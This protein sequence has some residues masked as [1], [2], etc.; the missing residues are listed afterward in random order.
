VAR[1]KD[2]PLTGDKSATP[3]QT[4]TPL[5]LSEFPD[6][7]FEPVESQ[8]RAFEWVLFV[9]LVLGAA[10]AW[11][12]ASRRIE[13][14]WI[15]GDE[16]TYSEYAKSFAD[17][18][19]FTFRDGHGAYVSIYPALIAAAWLADS[20]ETAYSAAKAINVLLMTL[21]AIPLFLWARRLV[22]PAYALIAVLLTLVMPSFV[23][24]GVLMTESAFLPAFVLATFAVALTLERPTLFRQLLA[25][26]AIALAVLIRL[27]GFVFL[28]IVPTAIVLMALFDLRAER[29]SIRPRSLGHNLSPYAAVA[30]LGVVALLA[31]LVAA[32]ATGREVT[33]V[34]SAYEDVPEADYTVEEVLRWTVTHLGELSLAVGLIPV[35][36]LIV[37]L[38][39]AWQRGAPFTPSQRAFLAVTAAAIPWVVLQAAAF[40]SE[41]SLR[42]QERNMLYLSPL[43]FLALVLWL[44]QGLPRPSG[45]T[46]IAVLLPT[47]LLVAVPL[48]TLFNPSLF[49]DSFALIPFVRLSDLL[50]GGIHAA[51]IVLVVGAIGAGLLFAAFPRRLM[52]PAIPAALTVFLALSAYSVSGAAKTQS[53][54]KRVAYLLGPDPNWID[55]RLGSDGNAAFLYTPELNADPDVVLQSEFWNRSVRD[56]YNV[57]APAYIFP[58]RDLGF[59]PATG[60]L[61][62]ADDWSPSA[63]HA[64]VDTTSYALAGTLIAQNGRLGL[65]RLAAPLRVAARSE[66]VQPDGWIENGGAYTQYWNPTNAPGTIVV[67]LSRPGVNRKVPPTA[68]HVE[69]RPMGAGE[70]VTARRTETIRSGK[71]TTV[72]LA[73][74]RPPFRVRVR[75]DR[76]FSPA[77]FGETDTRR[78]STRV[79]FKFRPHASR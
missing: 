20:I 68:V 15:M 63:P 60:L 25:V 43:F 49:T 47:A 28:A 11:I 40:A 30:G 37:L 56:V 14:P 59:D 39:L 2:R 48:E 31:Y 5:G 3:E 44:S 75:A 4:R 17:S 55:D 10:V 42:V 45:A 32:T 54:A 76:T 23:Y 36:A 71:V 46:S 65:Y 24:T 67:E 50:T 66:G 13:A 1:P 79:V 34:L 74:P 73:T 16:L 19:D 35:S 69:V 6:D 22:S 61:S 18:G 8:G 21:T 52:R 12:L 27:Q 78:L 64:V 72:R 26:A 33:A 38:A 70:R 9:G 58:G 41:Y 62:T 51:R 53:H 7:R 29:R 77:D 57:G